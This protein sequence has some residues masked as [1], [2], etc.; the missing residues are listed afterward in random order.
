MAEELLPQA[1]QVAV[2]VHGEGGP[3]DV[4]RLYTG[5]DDG[6]RMGLLVVLAALVDPDRPMRRLP[7]WPGLGARVWGSGA[8]PAP[9]AADLV[10]LVHGE[11]TPQEI[12]QALLRTGPEQ[13]EALAVALA[14]LV[15][16]RQPVKQALG[17]VDFTE[18]GELTVPSA[19]SSD[20]RIQHLAEVCEEPDGPD[21]AVDDIAVRLYLLGKPVSLNRAERLEAIR[22]AVGRD[23]S[24]VDV[25][26]MAGH[27]R[28]DTGTFVRRSHAMYVRD[29]L[30]WPLPEEPSFRSGGPRKLNARSARR[31]R[32]R[33]AKGGTSVLALSL[34]Y[35][36][37]RRSVSDVLWG[38]TF[39]NAGGPVKKRHVNRPKQATRVQWAGGSEGFAAAQQAD[40]A[41]A[42]CVTDLAAAA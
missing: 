38:R 34:A 16:P 24:Y 3:Q 4:H 28:G 32:E 18:H 5:L 15:D 11:G 12:H 1:A 29:G 35:K 37:S 22:I 21:D 13:R 17:W 40:A 9:V 36:V 26:R 41:W 19:W 23:M 14:A 31:I 42:E 27:K 39:P 30:V 6:R 20:M 33:Y 25:D 8:G 10:A 7:H 2:W